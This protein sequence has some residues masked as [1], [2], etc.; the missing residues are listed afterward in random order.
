[1]RPLRLLAR[2]VKLRRIRQC[3]R[4]GGTLGSGVCEH[5]DDHYPYWVIKVRLS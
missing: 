5:P 3:E 4:W 2:L 1:M